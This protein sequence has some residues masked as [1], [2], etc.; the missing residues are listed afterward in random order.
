MSPHS[1]PSPRDHTA[2]ARL[3]RPHHP[4]RPSVS[5]C[6]LCLLQVLGPLET[7]APAEAIARNL[8][9]GGTR[10]VGAVREEEAPVQVE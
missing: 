3:C 7:A 2:A 6:S 4:L 9:P 1:A 5:P 10:G 8:G